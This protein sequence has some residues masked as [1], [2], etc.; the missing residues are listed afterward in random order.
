MPEG[1]HRD[2]PVSIDEHDAG[3]GGAV[4]ADE[5]DAVRRFG[6]LAEPVERFVG[7]GPDVLEAAMQFVEERFAEELGYEFEG[8]MASV[9]T[10]STTP[11]MSAAAP[12]FVLSLPS[13]RLKNVAPGLSEFVGAMVGVVLGMVVPEYLSWDVRADD[14]RQLTQMAMTWATIVMTVAAMR[15]AL[16]IQRPDIVMTSR[17][18]FLRGYYATDCTI[19]DGRYS[20]RTT[21]LLYWPEL[22]TTTWSSSG[23]PTRSPA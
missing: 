20:G 21:M 10:A 16:L 19:I 7:Y 11:A 9:T 5:L 22:V 6:R 18:V 3:E 17:R 23:M 8:Q 14:S 1:Q 15:R 2:G 12:F 13:T 4:G